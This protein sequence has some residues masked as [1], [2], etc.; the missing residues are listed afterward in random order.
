MQIPIIEHRRGTGARPSRVPDRFN[1]DEFYEYKD[2]CRL[3][4]HGLPNDGLRRFEPVS[5][6]RPGCGDRLSGTIHERPKGRL[7]LVFLSPR[8]QLSRQKWGRQFSGGP[9][10]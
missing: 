5:D 6:Y 9:F 10:C 7:L 3:G 4:L 2:L 8:L 1:E